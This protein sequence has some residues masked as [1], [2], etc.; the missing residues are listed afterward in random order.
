M[1]NTIQHPFKQKWTVPIDN[2]GRFHSAFNNGLNS[3]VL[4]YLYLNNYIDSISLY[5]L[6]APSY[7]DL[8]K[9]ADHSQVTVHV[10]TNPWTPMTT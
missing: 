8:T 3:Q 1:K 9:K 7:Q 4:F 5:M 2:G 6:A 10:P